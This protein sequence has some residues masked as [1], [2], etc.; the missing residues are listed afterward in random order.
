MPSLGLGTNELSSSKA[1]KRKLEGHEEEARPTRQINE[2]V[3]LRATL[4]ARKSM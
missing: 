1:S 3:A 2:S 4:T